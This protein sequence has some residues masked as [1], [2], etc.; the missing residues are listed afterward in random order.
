MIGEFA[1]AGIG[2][3]AQRLRGKVRFGVVYAVVK[4]S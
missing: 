2:G 3:L 1:R 4:Q